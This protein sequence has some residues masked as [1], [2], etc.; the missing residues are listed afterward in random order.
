LGVGELT[1]V[2]ALGLIPFLLNEGWKSFAV[3]DD[4]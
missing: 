4:D 1:K 2:A 3:E